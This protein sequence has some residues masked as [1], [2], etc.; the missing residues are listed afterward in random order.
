MNYG[1]VDAFRDDCFEFG[2]VV[3]LASILCKQHIDDVLRPRQ[4][5]DMGGENTLGT[6]PH[7][8]RSG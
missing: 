1:I 2:G 7:N 6:Q 4:A 3:A 5:S 8:S